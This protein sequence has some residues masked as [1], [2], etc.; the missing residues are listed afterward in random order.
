MNVTA[1]LLRAATGCLPADADKF[2]QP[3]DDA[4][5]RFDITTP[6]RLAAFLA[7]LAHES[8][9]LRYVREIAGGQAYEGRRDLGNDRPGDG[10]RYRGRGL[11]QIT[12]RANY[13]ATAERLRALDAP[14]FE[15]F[16][17][18][19]EEPK[20]A[21]YSAADWWAAH[22]LSALAD[23]GEFDDIG[24]VINTGRRGRVPNGAADRRA[25]W[26]RA[27]QALARQNDAGAPIAPAPIPAP[28][29]TPAAAPAPGLTWPFQRPEEPTMP[30]PIV[31]AAVKGGSFLLGLANTLITLFEPLAREKVQR[32]I[33]RHTDRPE[34]AEQIAAAV[35]DAAKVATGKADPVQAVATAAEAHQAGDSTGVQAAQQGALDTLDRLAPLLERVHQWQMQGRAADEASLDAASRRA[36]TLAGDRVFLRFG[37]V[38]QLSFIEAL[39]LI[40]L[41]ISAGGALW[42][43]LAGKLND[44]LLGAIVT[45]MLIAGYT[46]VREFWLGSSRGSDS[47][48]MVLDELARRG[49]QG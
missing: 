24:S 25:R 11:L 47:K 7:Q 32:E 48:Q 38:L 36:V 13:R 14:D 43:G 22:G 40:L 30:A 28:Q 10:P 39:S 37:S 6:D 20:W 26:E 18:A 2:A 4:C 34:V 27:K 19:L 5:R 15:D 12:G 44:Q 1:E 17:E 3:L 46:G 8:G 9:A 45:L 31:A 29:P 33:G 42:L 23:A 41:A 49:K 35:V 16:P 21:A